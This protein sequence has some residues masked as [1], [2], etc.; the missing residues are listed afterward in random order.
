[1]TV[2]KYAL[3]LAIALLAVSYAVNAVRGLGPRSEARAVRVQRSA[4]R[5]SLRFWACVVLFLLALGVVE[6]AEGDWAQVLVVGLFVAA[7]LPFVWS[8]RGRL[9][10][11][12]D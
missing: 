12:R 11:L 4:A 9:R 1:M 7:S 2:L 6:A 8:A 5:T 3:V 10:G